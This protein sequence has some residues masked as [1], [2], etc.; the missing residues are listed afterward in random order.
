MASTDHCPSSVSRGRAKLGYEAKGTGRKA[1]W[2][3]RLRRHLLCKRWGVRGRRTRLNCRRPINL[4]I[5][6]FKKGLWQETQSRS[7]SIKN[8]TYHIE[9]LSHLKAVPEMF[10]GSLALSF[11]RSRASWVPTILSL[12]LRWIEE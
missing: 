12:D 3:I 4:K 8:F 7:T 9:H 2:V 5:K 10:S 1:I 11:R 6:A